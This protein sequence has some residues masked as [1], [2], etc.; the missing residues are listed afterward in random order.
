MLAVRVTFIIHHFDR[1]STVDE[2][3]GFVVMTAIIIFDHC[4]VKIH[5]VYAVHIIIETGV[6]TDLVIIM[7][8]AC[9]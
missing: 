8:A 4:P 5:Y 1:I 3:S 9:C 2:D 6:I 7:P